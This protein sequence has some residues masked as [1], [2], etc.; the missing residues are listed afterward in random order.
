[1]SGELRIALGDEQATGS[2]GSSLAPVLRSGVIYLEGELGAGKTTLARGLLRARGATGAIRS[3]TYT[4]L[5]PYELPGGTVL[6]MDLYRLRDPL[7]LE[8]LG[9]ADYPPTKALWL[10]EWPDKGAGLLPP[11]SL[12]VRL[13][14]QGDARIARL[15]GDPAILAALA[16]VNPPVG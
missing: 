7:E 13:A 5:E 16:A 6:H 14:G 3:P 4:L 8:N 12:R 2:L 9:L 1:M 15:D 10:V 11:A